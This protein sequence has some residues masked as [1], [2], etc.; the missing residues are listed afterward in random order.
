MRGAEAFS[1]AGDP[2]VSL[3]SLKSQYISAQAASAAAAAAAAA[4]A[5]A[6]FENESDF[7]WR[8]N[9]L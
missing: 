3:V 1:S 5:T 8:K 7:W 4:A 9:Y 6:D 2:E